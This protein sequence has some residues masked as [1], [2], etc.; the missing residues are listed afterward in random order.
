MHIQKRVIGAGT[1]DNFVE[2]FPVPIE[3]KNHKCWRRFMNA[4]ATDRAY[5]PT[6][7]GIFPSLFSSIL[8]IFVLFFYLKNMQQIV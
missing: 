4:R 7:H 2:K 8:I 6:I 5:L 1:G 3:Q